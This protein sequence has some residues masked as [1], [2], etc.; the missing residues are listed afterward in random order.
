MLRGLGRG[1]QHNIRIA[2]VGRV[3]LFCFPFGIGFLEVYQL[4]PGF[5]GNEVGRDESSSGIKRS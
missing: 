3:I 5:G 1:Y 4:I 2:A